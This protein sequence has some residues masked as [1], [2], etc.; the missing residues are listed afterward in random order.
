MTDTSA[1]T[2]VLDEETVKRLCTYDVCIEHGVGTA[3]CPI[4]IAEHHVIDA[5]ETE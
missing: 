4:R 5:L 1:P 2:R 3:G